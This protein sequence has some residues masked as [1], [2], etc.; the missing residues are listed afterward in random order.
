M[1]KTHI[2]TLAFAT[3]GLVSA[4]AGS[5]YVSYGKSPKAPA[6]MEVPSLCECF[7]GNTSNVSV[8]AAGILPE[9]ESEEFEDSLGGGIAMS[10]FFTEHV[11]LEGSYT[12]YSTD[13]VVHQ[14]SGSLILRLP[15]KSLCL[16]PY[17]LAGG[18]YH[19]N[20]VNQG[21]YHAGAG[22][23]YRFAN[24]FGIFADAQ[25]NW[26]EDTVDYTTVRGGVRFGF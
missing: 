20:S 22:L 24:C 6:P 18:S 17:L 21:T 23:D 11:G 25:Y 1:N 8:Y 26:A 3:L 13:T 7:N 9:S 14:I 15:I 19:T 4:Q 10:Y 12:A 16:A 2:A 5:G